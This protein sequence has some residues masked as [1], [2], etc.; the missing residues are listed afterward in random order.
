MPPFNRAYTTIF[1]RFR[2]RAG[3]LSNSKVADFN[4]PHLHLAP[5]PGFTPVKFREDLWRQK[6][7][8]HSL[9]YRVV[10]FV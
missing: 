7:E 9:G 10:L 1:Y 2:D 6:L 8:S 3:Y 5:P 4:Q